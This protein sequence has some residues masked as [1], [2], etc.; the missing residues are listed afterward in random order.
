MIALPVALLLVVLGCLAL[1]LFVVSLPLILLG[2]W[3]RRSLDEW[4]ARRLLLSL[5]RSRVAGV[6]LVPAMREPP[7][8]EVLR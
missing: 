1:A 3:L 5:Y 7:G 4:K 6:E 8:P 2:L